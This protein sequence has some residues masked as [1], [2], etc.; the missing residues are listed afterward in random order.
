MSDSALFVVL[1]EDRRHQQLA[2]KYLVRRF[3]CD[4]HAIRLLELPSGQGAGEQ[5]VRENYPKQLEAWRDRAIRARTALIAVIDADTKTVAE[6]QQQLRR[7][8]QE[9]GVVT[10]GDGD[11]VVHLIPKRNVETWVLCLTGVTVNEI[12]DYKN[13][14]ANIDGLIGQGIETLYR[15]SR[16]NAQ[17][18]TGC[19]S[20]LHDGIGEL[21]RL[22]DD[23]GYRTGRS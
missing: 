10:R 3:Q 20:S 9:A 2:R 22:E 8:A 23:R 1:A 19:V 13:A 18:P 11:A 7:S 14:T 4:M 16:L 17:I 15:W 6:R 5:W 12:D 21:Q